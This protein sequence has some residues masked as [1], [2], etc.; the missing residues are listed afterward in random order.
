[1]CLDEAT[2]NIDE[3]SERLVMSAIENHFDDCTIL[4]IAHRK[5][6]IRNCDRILVMKNGSVETFRESRRLS[7]DSNVES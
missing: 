5:E 4:S 7:E 1:L 2:A 6:T 3:D